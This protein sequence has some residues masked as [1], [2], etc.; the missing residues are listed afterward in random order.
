MNRD[1]AP[2]IVTRKFEIQPAGSQLP[3]EKRMCSLTLIAH[4]TTGTSTIPHLISRETQLL[5]Q[6]KSVCVM[7]EPS[8]SFTMFE[9]GRVAKHKRKKRQKKRIR[10]IVIHG[11]GSDSGD[12]PNAECRV[13]GH[14][15][16]NSE[17]IKRSYKIYMEAVRL[18][19]VPTQQDLEERV[20][21]ANR[22]KRVIIGFYVCTMVLSYLVIWLLIF[23]LILPFASILLQR[24]AREAHRSVSSTSE[25][26][27]F[28]NDY[29]SNYPEYSNM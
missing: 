27:V 2:Y 20:T 18:G 28:E 15:E 8:T 1:Y 24:F 16:L 22:L 4:S 12:S 13:S 6:L 3:G 10:S 7:S 9:R 17:E 23:A 11:A 29:E 26:P 5:S 19:L 14:S 21:L 25:R